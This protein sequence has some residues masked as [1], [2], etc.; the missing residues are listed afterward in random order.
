MLRWRVGDVT[1]TRVMDDEFEL[2]VPQDERTAAAVL[3]DASWLAPWA[4]T[5]D[6]TLRIGSSATLI[7]SQGR[8][9]VVDP[10]LAFD[11]PDADR[12]LDALA[13]AGCKADDV[14][15]VVNT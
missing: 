12:L 1:V 8:R 2:L 4:I 5:D 7:E 15:V 6:G 11:P 9:I 14:D 13:Q 3:A 10:W